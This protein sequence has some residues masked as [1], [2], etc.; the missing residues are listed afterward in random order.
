M[1]HFGLEETLSVADAYPRTTV[2]RTADRSPTIIC[3]DT[4]HK[5]DTHKI[6]RDFKK[7]LLSSSKPLNF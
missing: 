1:L 4:Y 6:K 3:L 5:A 2:H 7:S